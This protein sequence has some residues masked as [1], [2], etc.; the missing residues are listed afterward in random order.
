MQ[1]SSL[2]IKNKIS[3]RKK[4][5]ASLKKNADLVGSCWESQKLG[6]TEGYIYA[7]EELLGK[8]SVNW[9]FMGK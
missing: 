7:L 4:T 1:I 6:F 2:E 3:E 8:G 5:I 9:N